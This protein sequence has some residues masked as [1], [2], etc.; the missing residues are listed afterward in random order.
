MCKALM[1]QNS[2]FSRMAFVLAGGRSSRMGADKAFLKV[3]KRTLLECAISVLRCVSSDV[4]IVGDPGKFS[5]YGTVVEDIYRGA[6]PLAGIDAALQHSRA[7]LN[8]LLAVDLPFVSASLLS[9]LLACAEK[10]GAVVTVPRTASGFQP[11]CAVYR[12]AFA[13]AAEEAL[14]AGKNKIDALFA[15][16]T[17]RMIDENELRAAGFSEKVFSNLNTPEDVQSVMPDLL[18][19]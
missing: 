19:G 9:F 13:A 14:R 11:L 6:G 5:A 1:S 8:L 2:Q 12:R 7:D 10:S 4:A 16:T 17:T 3:G 15:K 18:R